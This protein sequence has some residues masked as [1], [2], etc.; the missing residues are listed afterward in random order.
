MIKNIKIF[1]MTLRSKYRGY[2]ETLDKEKKRL[3]DEKILKK[4][5]IL[6]VYK[7]ADI[8]FT[9]V[10]KDIEVDTYRL[11]EESWQNGKK[12]AVPKCKPEAKAMDF[13]IIKSFDD[14]E[15]C[16]FGL[17][18]PIASRCEKI[19]DF[20]SRNVCIVPGFCFDNEGFRL[21]YGYG[22]YDR[23][24][25]NFKGT[26]VGIC[27]SDSIIRRLPHGRFD[28]PIDIL[29][30][31]TY[32]KEINDKKRSLKKRGDHYEKIYKN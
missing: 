24:L 11:M 19:T 18:E 16:T 20:S 25:Q 6:N 7:Y 27:Y 10:S 32:I 29:L 9:Y 14:L 8:V 4:I 28:R 1:K 31:D 30:T 13:Y 26:A 23:F 21:G 17:L 3:M 15:K 2:R 12:V 22:Y 5:M